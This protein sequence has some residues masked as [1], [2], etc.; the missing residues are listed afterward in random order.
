MGSTHKRE[1]EAMIKSKNKTLK[2]IAVIL[3]ETAGIQPLMIFISVCLDVDM[4]FGR[5]FC[6]IVL[7]WVYMAVRKIAKDIF[8]S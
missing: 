6:V 2:H 4:S 7:V 3:I 8:R 1:G 5:I